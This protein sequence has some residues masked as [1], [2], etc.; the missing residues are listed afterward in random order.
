MADS[1]VERAAALAVEKQTDDR[2]RVPDIHWGVPREI[3]CTCGWRTTRHTVS[4]LEADWK[5]HVAP[6]QRKKAS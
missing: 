1:F 4:E 2:H 6:F 3:T 5:A